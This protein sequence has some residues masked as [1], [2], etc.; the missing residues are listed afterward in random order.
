MGQILLI[1][2]FC[3][4]QLRGQVQD[5]SVRKQQNKEMNVDSSATEHVLLS[6]ESHLFNILRKAFGLKDI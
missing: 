5:H 1:F 4:M 6:S 2:I 3:R